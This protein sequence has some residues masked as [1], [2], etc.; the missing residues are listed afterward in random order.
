MNDFNFLFTYLKKEEILLDKSEFLFQIQ[1]H[2]EYPSL[3]AISDTLTFFNIN[4][5][6]IRVAFEEIDNIPSQFVSLLSKNP[7]SSELYFIE[8]KGNTFFCTKDKKTFEISKTELESKWG[9]I[10]FLAEKDE[11]GNLIDVK[12]NNF[13]V[14][15][16]SISLV[17]FI[18]ILFLFGGDV[19]TNM[20]F[21]FPVFGILFSIAA[22]KDLFGAKSELISNFCNI[23]AST[24]CDTVVNSDKWKIFKY[25]NFSDLSMVFFASQ[26]F[27][28][29]TF[30]LSN[31]STSFFFIQKIIM[32]LS[33]PVILLSLYY[34]KIIEKKWCPICLGIISII[35]LEMI[36]LFLF[37]K[38][39][40]MISYQSLIV[41]VFVSSVIFLFWVVLKKN[42]I[43]QKDLKEFQS[44]GN[45]FMRNYEIF[46]SV[47]LSNDKI[48]LAFSPV[49]LGNKESNI[50]IT[51]ITSPFCG[52]CKDAH[53]I[54]EKILIATKRKIKVKILINANIDSLDVEK[55]IFFRRLMSI[56]IEK[57]E[58]LFLEALH[59]WFTN[60]NLKEWIEKYTSIFDEDK[61]DSIYRFQNQ[62]CATNKSHLTPDI[63]I[64]GYRYPK[65]YKREDLEFFINDL[66]EDDFFAN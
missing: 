41:Y 2:P 31:D 8:K 12:K 53:D 4:N 34:Q 19:E 33:F 60:K 61:I 50:E 15:W 3:L 21:I 43:L 9:G 42:L 62:W 27:G 37:L 10:V 46:K 59:S 49:I 55:K 57:G 25:L 32:L 52:Y 51:I 16:T 29:L 36:Y 24:S 17:L 40:F 35:I 63:F 38:G 14:I 23:T 22:L 48:E 11:I 18:A 64:N 54:L 56:Y 45:R 66:I 47:L 44:T 30:I 65:T 39:G 58:S 20:F 26:F 5:I 7:H 6:A 13:I 1:S 28:L